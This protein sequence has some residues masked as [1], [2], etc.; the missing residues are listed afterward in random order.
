[1][2]KV[3]EQP[4]DLLLNRF[5]IAVLCVGI[6]FGLSGCWLKRVD[7]DDDDDREDEETTEKETSE[8]N[9]ATTTTSA[10]TTESVPEVTTT[11][12]PAPTFAN[13]ANMYSSYA[14]MVSFDPA[15]GW[16][17]FDYFD[18]LKG[19]D[20]IDWLVAQEGYTVAE[21]EEEVNN[22]ADGEYVYKNVNPQLRTAD[23]DAV[24]ITMMYEADG[25]Q[26]DGAETVALTYSEFL[27]LYTAHPSLVVDGGFFFHVTVTG[28]VITEVDQVY[29]C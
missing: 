10:E 4:R 2:K 22:Y 19:Q 11:E 29:W 18:I 24:A 28:N 3:L 12:A 5:I 25:T 15:T 13:P 27:A 23:M 17:E 8:T 16:A 21:A 6:I 26:V 20:A 1:M 7:N 14:H 9:E